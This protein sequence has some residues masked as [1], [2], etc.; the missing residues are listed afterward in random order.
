MF[1]LA[2]TSYIIVAFLVF[3]DIIE[4]STNGMNPLCRNALQEE[5]GFLE[6]KESP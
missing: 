1:Y 4:E 3:F 5:L 2:A 6:N